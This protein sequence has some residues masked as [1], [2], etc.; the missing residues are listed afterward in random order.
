MKK[1]SLIFI[2]FI[3]SKITNAQIYPTPDNPCEARAWS[4]KPA[5]PLFAD[6]TPVPIVQNIISYT[7]ATLTGGIANPSCIT[8]NAQNIRDIW[9]RCSVPTSGRLVIRIAEGSTDLVMAAYSKTGPCNTGTYTEVGCN[10]DYLGNINPRLQLSGLTPASELYIRIFNNPISVVDNGAFYICITDYYDNLPVVDNSSKVGIGAVSPF[11]KLDVAGSGIFRDKTQF[12]KDIEVRGRA[13]ITGKLELDSLLLNGGGFPGHYL[14]SD[15]F[16]GLATWQSLP[17][18]ASAWN[19]SGNN[20]YNNNTANIGIGNTDPSFLLDLSKRMRLRSENTSLGAGIWF[21][22]NDNSSLN[23]FLGN[24][25]N[26]NLQIFSSSGNRT[27]ATFNPTSGGLRVEGPTTEASGNAIASF[28]GYGNF[29]VDKP[30]TA[31]GRFII[32]EN[33]NV[34]IGTNAPESVLE[35][36]GLTNH[37]MINENSN[38]WNRI[39][40]KNNVGQGWTLATLTG[41]TATDSRFNIFSDQSASNILSIHGNGAIAVNGNIGAVGQVLTSNGS[42]AANYSGL[43][44]LTS[45]SSTSNCNTSYIVVPNVNTTITCGTLNVN[46]TNPLGAKLLISGTFSLNAGSCSGAGCAAVGVIQVYVDGVFSTGIFQSIG[47]GRIEN[48]TIANL[49]HNVSSGIHTI[50]FVA[51]IPTGGSTTFFQVSSNYTSAFALSN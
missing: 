23:T 50:T 19:V 41:A 5:D 40:F 9:L 33:G 7:N 37:L 32:K 28:G 16:T 14:T 43:S 46:V 47:S 34:G 6:C 20:M 31:G 29:V 26:N 42:A 18:S 39:G 21:N 8:S 15:L 12:A 13:K 36:K 44:T 49:L 3:F 17:A 35:L 45:A 22:N 1:I 2:C 25:V 27:I 48:L 4:V 10:N 30:G 51:Q 38:F 11:A 24:D